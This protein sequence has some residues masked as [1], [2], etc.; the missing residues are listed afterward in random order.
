ML[1]DGMADAW[2]P[3]SGRSPP[4]CDLKWFPR[5]SFSPGGSAPGHDGKGGSS[6]PTAAVQQTAIS[7][8]VPTLSSSSARPRNFFARCV[9][10]MPTR[11]LNSSK[12][13][14]MK[15]RWRAKLADAPLALA[16][17]YSVPSRPRLVQACQ[18]IEPSRCTPQATAPGLTRMVMLPH[19]CRGQ[20]FHRTV[21]VSEP[22]MKLIAE[23]GGRP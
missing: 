16:R 10:A 22:A 7:R 8:S 1:A 17:S 4:E 19:S 23:R 14:P 9:A 2:C 18:R 12:F 11:T 21:F 15:S 20:K 3:P 13:F 5:T 6:C